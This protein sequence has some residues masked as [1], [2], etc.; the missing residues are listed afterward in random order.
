MQPIPARRHRIPAGRTWGA[1]LVALLSPAVLPASGVEPVYS[2]APY[3]R[4]KS[5]A[6][7]MRFTQGR[8][9]RF[10]ADGIDPEG[11]QWLSGH[12][13]AAEVRFFVDGLQVATQAQWPGQVNHFETLLT[14][15]A[16]GPHTLTTESRNFGEV[17][18]QSV[19]PVT[20]EVEPF[21]SKP[22]TVVLTA[23]LVLS[24]NQSL[25]W[26]D[27]VV[28]GNGFQVRSAAGWTGGVRIRNSFVT[29]L[30]VTGSVI[31]TP[32]SAPRDG[33]DVATSGGSVEI[34]DSVFE[35]TGAVSLRVD[36]A[37][38]ITVVGNE[39]RANNFIPFVSWQPQRSPILTF[40]GNSTGVKRL[41][42]NRI[43]AGIV[44]VDRMSDW[45]IG[46]D[47]DAES[48]LL[49][50]PRC[51]ID[52]TG[53]ARPRI[54]GNYIHHDYHGGWSQGFNVVLSGTSGALTEH[55]V[56]YA[57]SWPVQSPG[58]DFR[59][60]LVVWVGHNW[61]RSPQSGARIYRNVFISPQPAGYVTEGIWLY[62]NQ[63]DVQVYNN[64]FDGGGSLLDYFDSA[65]TVSS[66]SS[67]SQ[68]KNNVFTGMVPPGG[69]A[70]V[71]R[72]Q[73]ES[74]ANPRLGY[75]DYNA[76][77]NPEVAVADNYAGDLVAGRSE[78]TDGFAGHDLGGV[79]GQ[80]NPQFVSGAV[81]PFPVSEDDVWNRRLR[82]SQILAD[83]RVRY[84]PAAGSP[85]IDRGDPADGAG[86]DMGAIEAPTGLPRP[87][88]QF[89]R[90][91][92]ASAPPTLSI[93]DLAVMEGNTGTTSATFTVTMSAASSA[94]VIVSY[95][96]AAGTATAGVDFTA[97]SGTLSF[98]PGTTAR[99]VVVPVL[100]DLVGESD[101][102]VL[103][104][105]SS[106]VNAT[107]RD[108]A[109]VGTILDDDTPRGLHVLTPCRLVDTRGPLGPTGGPAMG[110]NSSRTFPATGRCGVPATARAVAV[111]IVA[112]NPGASG[113]LRL[114]PAGTAA[115]LASSLN[116]AQGRTRANNGIIATGA[117]GQI[118]VRCD[119][120]VG[121]TA[122][123]HFVADLYGFFE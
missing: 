25:D 84:S 20:I 87:E 36:G 79:N 117:G 8:P 61:I 34:V 43:G 18:R 97:V 86:V 75:A 10:L 58:G 82:V 16:P 92:G 35:W 104:S 89:G 28:N 27:A 37:G 44:L 19:F 6:D 66:G 11:W 106:P 57:S 42:G 38:D 15:L 107:L 81:L 59:Y 95:G 50:G 12:Q 101:E 45:L 3:T 56:I 48:N 120:P 72:G 47:T 112:V 114:Y 115:P 91:G 77:W 29:G 116:F 24:G 40:A 60:N 78:G 14:G 22:N 80:V 55:N 76:F 41:Q 73:G 13:E 49:I 71:R 118:T 1:M 67:I 111:N 30:A 102:T 2:V 123:T 122:V 21:P 31:P 32:E 108:A 93:D 63:T 74:D 46:G 7:G 33:I 39:L 98:P 26:T 17:I 68:L 85:L 70:M 51:V 113:S 64:T 109:A 5:P 121:S 96:A 62:G 54:R 100:G 69:R 53:S 103:V 99:P 119:M 9:I 65:I 52:V 110:A 105:L 23:D 90:F 83:Y 94:A 4:V 88:D